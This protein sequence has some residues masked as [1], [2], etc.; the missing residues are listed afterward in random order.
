MKTSSLPTPGDAAIVL[1]APCRPV[2]QWPQADLTVWLTVLCLGIA[3][4]PNADSWLQ[5]DRSAIAA[6]QWWRVVTGHFT[7]WNGEH[8]FWDLSIFAILGWICERKDRSRFVIG[9][10]AATLLI[11]FAGWILLPV[12]QTYR[13][14]S[15]LDTAL[16]TLLAASALQANWREQ[17][18]GWVIAIGA[19]LAGLAAKIAFEMQ[20]AGALF[21]DTAGAGFQPVPLAHIIGAFVGMV[22]G[23]Y[24]VSAMRIDSPP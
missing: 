20:S 10:S 22:V 18:W 21:V 24:P 15:G 9:L 19:L 11:S 1:F 12:L 2:R 14:L 8:L 7:H 5:F 17:Q 3:L 13:G 23:L 4:L 6:G 16:F